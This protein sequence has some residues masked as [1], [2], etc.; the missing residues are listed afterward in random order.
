MV[1]SRGADLTCPMETAWRLVP[2]LYS[3]QITPSAR[4]ASTDARS[5]VV[6]RYG[7]EPSTCALQT[8][9]RPSTSDEISNAETGA[10]GSNSPAGDAA[11]DA[12]GRDGLGPAVVGGA[13]GD[14]EGLGPTD[15]A[16]HSVR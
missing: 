10:P 15:G 9:P 4:R 14:S 11:G 1:I 5:E 12:G 6:Q 3:D 13:D 16:E 7:S 2:G 8:P